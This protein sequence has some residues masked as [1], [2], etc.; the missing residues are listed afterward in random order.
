MARRVLYRYLPV[1]IHS[2]IRT[3]DHHLPVPV[4]EELIAS[5]SRGSNIHGGLQQC[6]ARMVEEFLLIPMGS[7]QSEVTLVQHGEEI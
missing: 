3:R 4:K 7:V 1:S 2:Y 5:F 6:N